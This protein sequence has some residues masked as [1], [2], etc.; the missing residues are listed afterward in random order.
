MLVVHREELK[1]VGLALC[2]ILTFTRFLLIL[3]LL[4]A[5]AIFA[6]FRVCPVLAT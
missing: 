3:E 4:D 2:L 6:P 5:A 1:R